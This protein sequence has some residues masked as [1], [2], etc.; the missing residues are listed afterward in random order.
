MSKWTQAQMKKLDNVGASAMVKL[1]QQQN[2]QGSSMKERWNLAQGKDDRWERSAAAREQGADPDSADQDASAAP[3]SVRARAAQMGTGS[4]SA[5]AGK[6]PPPPPPARLGAVSS[7][8]QPPPPPA[9]Q[10]STGADSTFSAGSVAT[11]PAPPPRSTFAAGAAQSAATQPVARSA[12]AAATGLKFSEL[13]AT[14]KEAFFSLLDE[15]FSSR[16]F[17]QQ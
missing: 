15:Y 11:P 10:P 1:R 6:G 5:V 7:Q 16:G 14:E 17:F 2:A 3:F 12:A 4:G 9:R 8:A 13:D